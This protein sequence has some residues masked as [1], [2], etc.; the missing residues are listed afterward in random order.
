ML[1]LATQRIDRSHGWHPCSSGRN[2]PARPPC[3]APPSPLPHSRFYPRRTKQPELD[4]SRRS[5]KTV[6]LGWPFTDVRQPWLAPVRIPFERAVQLVVALDAVLRCGPSTK[7][8]DTAL[9]E[10][11]LAL[12]SGRE[13]SHGCSDCGGCG[14]GG[15]DG[16]RGSNSLKLEAMKEVMHIL[17]PGVGP[18][19]SSS[20]PPPCADDEFFFMAR[21]VLLHLKGYSGEQDDRDRV[22]LGGA[23]VRQALARS[24]YSSSPSLFL[25]S[26]PSEN[27]V[28]LPERHGKTTTTTTA[29]LNSADQTTPTTTS[30]GGAAASYGAGG[31]GSY[32]VFR[33]LGPGTSTVSFGGACGIDRHPLAAMS[34][35]N[36]EENKEEEGEDDA[37]APRGSWI[38]GGSITVGIFGTSKERRQRVLPPGADKLPLPLP[39][40]PL[41]DAPAEPRVTAVALTRLQKERSDSWPPFGRRDLRLAIARQSSK[42]SCSSQG[43]EERGQGRND[44]GLRRDPP[45]DTQVASL[46][47]ECPSAAVSIVER[48]TTVACANRPTVFHADHPRAEAS[49]P[50][51]LRVDTSWGRTPV[52]SSTSLRGTTVAATVAAADTDTDT[53]TAATVTGRNS[54]F[55]PASHSNQT[56]AHTSGRQV[57]TQEGPAARQERG[58]KDKPSPPPQRGRPLR[59]C[60]PAFSSSCSGSRPDV[61]SPPLAGPRPSS[62]STEGASCTTPSSPSAK[63]GL[64]AACVSPSFFSP[65]RGRCRSPSSPR[66]R[67][68]SPSCERCGSRPM[69]PRL[70]RPGST[71]PS[72]RRRTAAVC[73]PVAVINCSFPKVKAP[74]VLPDPDTYVVDTKVH[75]TIY[76]PLL[77]RSVDYIYRPLLHTYFYHAKL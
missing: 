38:R 72:T 60:S 26:S 53:N 57:G 37:E 47:T 55:P 5:V 3:Y 71:S 69:S 56:M 10:S 33:A 4:D 16:G 75:D 68:A 51:G 39:P 73:S 76:S 48:E 43:R 31:Q 35:K 15:G 63:E 28:A 29:A 19:V 62:E 12:R 41:C 13:L 70:A 25:S 66:G 18:N 52:A 44:R 59:P 45:G 36:E 74:G 49:G 42:V 11:R 32:F 46:P 9:E 30:S 40:P 27:D 58:G 61:L 65:R 1:R 7:A 77:L 2:P 23:L 54:S 14:G 24:T 64:V 21:W 17:W 8:V 67:P 6:L 34:L 20:L 22:S 50:S